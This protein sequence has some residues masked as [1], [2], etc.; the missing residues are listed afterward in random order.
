ML[1]ELEA[2]RS[3]RDYLG[4]RP[5]LRHSRLIALKR[6]GTLLESLTFEDSQRNL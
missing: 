5:Q 4:L 6:L 2:V 3:T 1:G